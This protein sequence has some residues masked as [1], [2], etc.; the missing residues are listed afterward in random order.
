MD[1][2]TFIYAT[3]VAL[4]SV[5]LFTLAP[6]MEANK[7]DLTGHLR[8]CLV[9]VQPVWPAAKCAERWL[10][11]KLFWHWG[12]G[13]GRVVVKVIVEPFQRKSGI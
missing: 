7:L 10:W 2:A 9:Q 11:P 8:K 6:M 1:W 3:A 13:A 5:L 4:V 12:P